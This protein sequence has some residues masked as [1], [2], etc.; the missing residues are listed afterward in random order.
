MNG[1]AVRQPASGLRR[2]TTV[3]LLGWV[4]LAASASSTLSCAED[5]AA[6]KARAGEPSASVCPEQ[7]AGSSAP[8]A[9]CVVHFTPG[10]QASFGH[11]QLPGVVLG[12]PKGGGEQQGSTDVASLGCG[13]EI[14]LA[15]DGPGIA[16]G[17]GA[18]LLIFENAFRY[19]GSGAEAAFFA[20]PAEVAVSGDGLSYRT[21]PCTI[22]PGSFPVGCAG[23]RP[24]LSSPENGVAP[25]DAHAAGGDAFD[26]AELGLASARYVRLSD[27]TAELYGAA[28]IYCQGASGGFDLDAMV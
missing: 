14:V 7:A 28:S 25:T 26:L 12:P 20:E 10:P 13:G 5:A 6:D 19:G 18:D 27:R 17:P 2:P 11:D 8:F 1:G 3:L 16:D 22:A 9:D 24:V 21:F 15:F 4:L 23:L